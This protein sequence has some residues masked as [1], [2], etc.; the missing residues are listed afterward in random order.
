MVDALTILFSRCKSAKNYLVESLPSET[1][2][3]FNSRMGFKVRLVGVELNRRISFSLLHPTKI[4]SFHS[5]GSSV[6]RPTTNKTMN[7][8]GFESGS[9]KSPS[10]S[11]TRHQTTGPIDWRDGMIK[12]EMPSA[13]QKAASFANI[14]IRSLY[15]KWERWSERINPPINHCITTAV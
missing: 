15:P 3:W 1:S 7:L 8:W 9:N 11:I 4:D 13:T 14:H 12:E 2:V 6:V 5:L 10:S